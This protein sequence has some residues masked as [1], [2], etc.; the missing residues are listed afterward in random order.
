LTGFIF[1]LADRVKKKRT[2]AEMKEV[3]EKALRSQLKP[4]FV[5]NALAAIQKYVREN[6][7]L[8]E[9]FLSK[10]S[11][12]TQEV[13]VNS[14]K[15]FIPLSDELAM[16]GKYIELHSLRLRQPIEYNFSIDST[17]D[18]DDI[19][20]PPAILQPLVE[21]SINHNFASKQHRGIITLSCIKED[22]LL[23]CDITDRC[24]GPAAQVEQLES[25]MKDRKS[26]GLEIV[27]ERLA[28]WSKGKAIKGF[29]ELFPQHDG[30]KVVLG[31]PQ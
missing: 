8:A 12:F 3:A 28:L 14:E 18:P 23:R 9:S 29:L 6:P 24:E 21:N 10:F 15:K 30:M 11:Q 31:I 20:V 22:G 16:L 2:Q 4:H 17:L 25:R 19:M 13:L 1:Y 26:F 5:F 7:V 27:R